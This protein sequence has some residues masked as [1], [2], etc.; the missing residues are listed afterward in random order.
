MKEPSTAK[1][2]QVIGENIYAT[3][4][5]ART[6]SRIVDT[7]AGGVA[8]AFTDPSGQ[9]RWMPV[10]DPI[11]AGSSFARGRLKHVQNAVLLGLADAGLASVDVAGPAS[12]PA[13]ETA[14]SYLVQLALLQQAT[15]ADWLDVNVD[16]VGDDLTLRARAMEWLVTTLED[17]PLVTVPV[18]LDSSNSEVLAAGL[19]CSKRPHGR[20]LLN[21]ASLERLDVL[22]LAVEHHVPLVVS[23]A[24]EA[25]LPT[26]VEGRLANAHRVLDAAAIRGVPPEDIYLGP[27]VMPAAVDHEAGRSFLDAARRL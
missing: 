19:R 2:F 6:G 5:I 24:G 10:C 15:G 4:T 22:D 14:R 16:E 18:S 25:S 13:A 3:R 12:P 20:P 7:D 9:V 11:A 27:L 8:V 26:N 23:A 1:R 17:S 21:S